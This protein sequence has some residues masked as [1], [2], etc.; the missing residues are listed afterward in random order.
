MATCSVRWRSSG[1]RGE[2]EYVPAE[3]LQDRVIEVYFEPIGV[4]IPAEVMGMKAQ[5][6]PRLRKVDSNNRKKLH[7]PQLVMAVARLPEPARS[8][9]GGNVVF[10]LEN[11]HFVMDEME[12]DIVED[13]G[14]TATLAPLR[15][16]ILHSEQVINLQDRVVALSRDLEQADEIAHDSPLLAAAIRAHGSE[17]RRGVNSSAIRVAAD[18]FISVQ[19]NTFGKN[20]AGSATV[21][22][23][24]FKAFELEPTDLE[25]AI[26]GKEGR[27]LARVHVYKERDRS[28]VKR[29]K[30]YFRDKNAGKLTCSSCGLDP[31]VR[32]ASGGDRAIEAHHKVPVFELQ[33]DSVTT[34]NDVVMVCAACHRVIHSQLPCLPFDAILS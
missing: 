2:F 30:K 11:K 12:F 18:T 24:A 3:T 13:D 16:S 29:A 20:N 5:G 15:V 14:Q 25:E 23:E 1:G 28:F 10:P 27:T 26:V 9:S 33:P 7:L 21:V 17:V 32:Y 19:A 8:D 31:E 6:K 34:V 22:R 4:T